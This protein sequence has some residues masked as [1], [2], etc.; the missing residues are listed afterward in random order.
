MTKK[1]FIILLLALFSMYSF[2]STNQLIHDSLLRKAVKI[3]LPE[4]FL[5]NLKTLSVSHP[6][7][8]DAILVNDEIAYGIPIIGVGDIML[9]TNF[10]NKSYLPANDGKD[11]LKPLEHIL[12]SA[13]VTFGNLEGCFLDEGGIVK[14]CGDPDICFA[15]R[16]PESYVEHLVNAGFDMMSIANNHLGD[17]GNAGRQKTVEVLENRNIAYAGLLNY[18]KTVVERNGIKFGMLAFSPNVGTVSIHDLKNAANLVKELKEESDIIIVSF[19]GGAEGTKHQNVK[20]KTEHYYGENRGNVCKFAKAVIDAGA[21]IVFG[22]GPHVT[23]SVDIYKDRFIIYSLGNFCT[24]GRFN[25]RGETGI[26]PIVKVY[27]DPGGKFLKAEVTPIVQLKRGEPRIDSRKRAIKSLQ[28]LLR[29]DFPD[30]RLQITDEGLI[31][32]SP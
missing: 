13:T 22:H 20:C 8:Y 21:D 16:M 12:K 7:G 27:V 4:D 25:L 11:L 30:S 3:E 28:R 24:Y 17:F 26:A 32:V 23:R 19:H 10:P 5:G 1:V 18:P 9:G 31:I 29:E 2:G 15:F 14:Q 6:P